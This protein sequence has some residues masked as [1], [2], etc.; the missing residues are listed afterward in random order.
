M[1]RSGKMSGRVSSRRK[2]L[3]WRCA[4]FPLTRARDGRADKLDKC[5]PK[6][7]YTPCLFHPERK[8]VALTKAA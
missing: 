3:R 5:R 1:Q 8:E 4:E 6:G 7:K 2:Q